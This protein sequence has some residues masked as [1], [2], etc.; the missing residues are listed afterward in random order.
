MAYYSELPA[1]P[2]LS[3]RRPGDG[4]RYQLAVLEWGQQGFTITNSP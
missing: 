3:K 4:D 1:E 2:K